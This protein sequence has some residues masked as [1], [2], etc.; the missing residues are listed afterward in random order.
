MNVKGTLGDFD[1]YNMRLSS[2]SSVAWQE[3]IGHRI[4][5]GPFA[6]IT[7]FWNC[8]YCCCY[9]C[10]CLICVRAGWESWKDTSI[11]SWIST[12]FSIRSR[13]TTS[14]SA[15]IYAKVKEPIQQ[16]EGKLDV[17]N[18]RAYGPRQRDETDYCGYQVKQCPQANV[19]KFHLHQKRKFGM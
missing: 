4:I 16:K 5:F 2:S 17:A 12:S 10:C 11:C 8:C 1:K 15:P 3:V 9:Y 13:S 19:S 7:R 18:Y 14:S 6:L